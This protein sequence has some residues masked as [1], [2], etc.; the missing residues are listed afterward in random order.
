MQLVP[1]DLREGTKVVRIVLSFWLKTF[2]DH[3]TLLVRRVSLRERYGVSAPLAR[4]A[5]SPPTPTLA[6]KRRFAP[7]APEIGRGGYF[8]EAGRLVGRRVRIVAQCGLP[9]LLNRRGPVVCDVASRVA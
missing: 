6:R 1:C 3:Q 8:V 5:P 4:A 2:A 9:M 7:L